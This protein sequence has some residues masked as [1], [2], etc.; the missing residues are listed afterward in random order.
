MKGDDNDEDRELT[1][2]QIAY[3]RSKLEDLSEFINGPRLT[4]SE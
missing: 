3:C 4:A 1:D 2:G